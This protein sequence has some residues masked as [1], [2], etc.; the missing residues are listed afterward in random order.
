MYFWQ[1]QNY[2]PR[3]ALLFHCLPKKLGT[4]MTALNSINAD[5]LNLGWRIHNVEGL[6]KSAL[7]TLAAVVLVLDCIVAFSYNASMV[8]SMDAL[9]SAFWVLVTLAAIFSALFFHSECPLGRN[10]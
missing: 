2:I 9:K 10:L 8:T 3:S 5:G 4:S 1:H 7:A 6:D